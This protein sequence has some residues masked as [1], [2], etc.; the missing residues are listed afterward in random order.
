[1]LMKVDGQ[2]R[3]VVQD[4]PDAVSLESLRWLDFY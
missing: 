3:N 1:M 4:E 2:L